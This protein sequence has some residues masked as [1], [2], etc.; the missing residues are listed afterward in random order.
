MFFA[1]KGIE[2]PK[3]KKFSVVKNVEN[4]LKNFLRIFA[5]NERFL[6]PKMG[7]NVK[8]CQNWPFLAKMTVSWSPFSKKRGTRKTKNFRVLKSCFR[9]SLMSG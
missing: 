1:R 2:N 9:V 6:G 8:N 3:N 4:L 7:K 5:K